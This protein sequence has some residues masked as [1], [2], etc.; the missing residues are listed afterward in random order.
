MRKKFNLRKWI[1]NYIF[2]GYFIA[3]LIVIIY[4]LVKFKEFGINFKILKGNFIVAFIIMPL[5]LG[6]K[7]LY[8]EYKEI[9]KTA[10]LDR[11]IF[12]ILGIIFVV[13]GVYYRAK[14]SGTF[15]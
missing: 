4:N 6:F 15:K 11:K 3:L 5:S 7:N 13:Y 12:I 9:W 2:Y 10:E 8:Y 14:I 1:F